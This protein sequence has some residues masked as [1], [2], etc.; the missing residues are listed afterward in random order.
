ML[1]RIET[2]E[3]VVPDEES[4]AEKDIPGRER[5]VPPGCWAAVVLDSRLLA[6][7]NI[8]ATRPAT[9]RGLFQW[10]YNDRIAT[11]IT[12]AASV[13]SSLLLFS[14][15]C[16]SLLCSAPL[17]SALL[18]SP[19]LSSPLCSALQASQDLCLSLSLARILGSRGTFSET[20]P[21]L[22]AGDRRG[23][24]S[25]SA[26]LC[27]QSSASLFPQCRRDSRSSS[28]NRR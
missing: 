25:L 27:G 2:R 16:S 4:R 5:S 24:M 23:L 13:D 20:S 15:L 14:L 19:L 10:P 6:T 9:V 1:V 17:F 7:L 26:L 8:V 3:A 22:L 28:M 21:L 18:L 11:S 12:A